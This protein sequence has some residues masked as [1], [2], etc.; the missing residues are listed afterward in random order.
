MNG[1]CLMYTK[2]SVLES[3]HE[4][5]VADPDPEPD[6]VKMGPDPQH[7]MEVLWKCS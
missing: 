7:C 1:E 5:S 4:S 2:K 3:V 6:P